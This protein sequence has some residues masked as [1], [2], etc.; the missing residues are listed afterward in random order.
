ITEGPY[1]DARG[2]CK[3]NVSVRTAG[4]YITATV[5]FKETTN[6]DLSVVVTTF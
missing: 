5:A 4:E 3:A 6:G 2:T 1:L